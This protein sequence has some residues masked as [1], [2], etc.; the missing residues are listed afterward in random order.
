[1]DEVR[2]G[3]EFETGDV[4]NLAGT[5]VDPTGK[6]LEDTGSSAHFNKLARSLLVGIITHV[7]YKREKT[8]EIASLDEID[9]I[10]QEKVQDDSYWE[11]LKKYKHMKDEKGNWIAH[12]LVVKIANDIMA[13]K[14]KE[15]GSIMTTTKNILSLYRDSVVA[16]NTS[17]SEFHISDLMDSENPIALYIIV[18]PSI[19]FDCLL[20]FEFL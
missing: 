18:Q 1:M 8:G 20:L 2:L 19:K 7:L 4:Q 14:E 10:L 6:G 13:V 5:L 16:K 15:R 11:E 3:T 12:P 17:C 9:I